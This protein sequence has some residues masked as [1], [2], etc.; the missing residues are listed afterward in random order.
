M[1]WVLR[2][3]DLQIIS[4]K[5]RKYEYFSLPRP[6]TWI[7]IVAL[8][9]L[10]RVELA[11]GPILII[12]A[13]QYP[14]KSEAIHPAATQSLHGGRALTGQACRPSARSTKTTNYIMTGLRHRTLSG[15]HWAL[16]VR[17]RNIYLLVI[18]YFALMKA[19]GH[20]C[21]QICPF[22]SSGTKIFPEMSDVFKIMYWFQI[23]MH[24]SNFLM[25]YS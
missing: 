18:A 19:K 24:Y 16:C 17:S 22:A 9:R 25:P 12:S 20:I 3:Y 7:F 11:P 8:G 10:K 13:G 21:Q 14:N 6:T 15:S 23:S 4:L 2:H 5:L 1:K